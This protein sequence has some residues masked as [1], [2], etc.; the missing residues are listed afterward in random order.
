MAGMNDVS[1]ELIHE[2][3]AHLHPS[4]IL[5]FSRVCKRFHFLSPAYVAKH[6]RRW[7]KYYEVN[8]LDPTTFPTIFRE[9]LLDRNLAWYIRRFV[10]YARRETFQDWRTV[11]FAEEDE[12]EEEEDGDMSESDKTDGNEDPKP[13]SGGAC[14]T[15]DDESNDEDNEEED[16]EIQASQSES[17][18]S[19]AKKTSSDQGVQVRE[20]RPSFYSPSDLSLF[21]RE[22]QENLLVLSH[23]VTSWIVENAEG[24]DGAQKFLVASRAPNLDTLTVVAHRNDDLFLHY[25]TQSLRKINAPFSKLQ[26]GEWF[27]SLSEVHIHHYLK[28]TDYSE[29]EMLYVQDWAPLLI[30]PSLI[31]FRVRS[32]DQRDEEQAYKWEFAPRSSTVEHLDLGQMDLQKSEVAE[33]LGGIRA[34]KS[35]RYDHVM[36][37]EF[38]GVE[39][40]LLQHF[41]G[42]L[43]SVI[44]GKINNDYTITSLRGFQMLKDI[45]LD[46]QQLFS[47]VTGCRPSAFVNLSDM[48]PASIVKLKVK[49]RIYSMMTDF[50][51]LNLETGLVAFVKSKKDKNPNLKAICLRELY[52]ENGKGYKNPRFRSDLLREECEKNGVALSDCTVNPC[53]MCVDRPPVLS[54]D[55]DEGE[56]M[57]GGDDYD[58]ED[59]E[60]TEYYDDE[61]DDDD[62]EGDDEV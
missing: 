33:L 60:D 52:V 56:V 32:G 53:S 21:R 34:L 1:N 8:D 5:D 35:F 13:P 7:Q 29:V 9:I 45:S 2:I 26:R 20:F 11:S 47:K 6:K 36:R 23:E 41:K 15:K 51:A 17:A 49:G 37:E 3:F 57:C 14:H 54:E 42:T 19:E 43:E 40:I 10:I 38:L 31:E 44:L 16:V 55:L 25:L 39:K 18:L 30:L 12:E 27:A 28:D 59:E 24:D 4:S 62:E 48:L 58:A 46:I 61:G 50:E 22:L